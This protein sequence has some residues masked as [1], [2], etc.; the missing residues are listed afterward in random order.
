MF[1][2]VVKGSKQTTSDGEHTQKKKKIKK[3]IQHMYQ[4]ILINGCY[5]Y[6]TTLSAWLALFQI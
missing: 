6:L 5:R 4:Y 1:V 2:L 3:K